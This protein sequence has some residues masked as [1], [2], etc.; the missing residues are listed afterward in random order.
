MIILV[1]Q[2]AHQEN[3]LFFHS[4]FSVRPTDPAVRQIFS[5]GFRQRFGTLRIVP[6]IQDKQ[7][8]T[9]QHL[10]T[11]GPLHP[12][13]ALSNCFL[14][15]TPSA[16]AKR[17]HNRQRRHGIVQLILSK[18]GK[19]QR[20]FFTEE[21]G[22]LPPFLSQIIK[23]LSLQTLLNRTDP[24]ITRN[25]ERTSFFL[26]DTP[27]HIHHLR[28]IFIADNIRPGFDDPALVAGDFRKGISQ[29]FRM[30]KTYISD[31]SDLRG[32]NNVCRVKNTAQADLQYDKIAFFLFKINK[33]DCSDDL[34]L[35]GMVLHGI[36]GIAHPRS[37]PAQSFLRNIFTA[38]LDPL[39]EILDIGGGIKACPVPGLPKNPLHHGTG[40][41]LA[42]AAC[43]MNKAQTLLRVSQQ[44]QKLLRP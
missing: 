36:C 38:D 34:K 23:G 37:D 22:G 14:R 39:A 29:V 35:R 9:G 16:A 30:L 24:A 25:M 43:H 33:S 12:G 6:A 10:K 15:N 11:R 5:K 3:S 18:E 1:R 8:M 7:R 42:V 4:V 26:T 28:N 19:T 40:T 32:I 13:K 27:H 41:S 44:P 20:L 17:L 21:R 2:H 31:H